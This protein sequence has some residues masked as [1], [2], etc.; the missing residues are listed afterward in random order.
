[1][2]KDRKNLNRKK[3]QP[4]PFA[5]LSPMQ[6]DLLAIA[7]IYVFTLILFRGIVFNNAAFAAGGDTATALSYQKVGEAI[8]QTE[9]VDPLWMP[10]FFSGMPT[11]G[12]VAYIP[13]NVSYLQTAVVAVLKLLFL[14]GTWSWLVVFYFL[15][16]VFMFF[17]MREWKISRIG[18]LLAAVTFLLSPFAIG[19]A[20]EGH[21]S[22]LMALVY[23][24]LFFLL[25]H[26]LFEKR[27][28][29]SFGLLS[30]CIGT[31]LL[32]NHMQMVY[33]NFMIVGLYLLYYVIR[34]ARKE[35]MVTVKRVLLFGG[36]MVI[37]LMIASYIYLS[38][39]EYS[40]Y[41]IRGSGTPGVAGGLNW[42][43]ATSWSWHPQELLTLL[44]PGFFG[45]QYPYYWGTMPFTHST[46]YIGLVPILLSIIALVYRRNTLA[47]FMGLLT[48]FMLFMSFGKHFAFFYSILFDYLPFFNKFR[49]PVMVLH[50]LPFTAAVLSAIG[51]DF[52]VEW[53][54]QAQE[55]SLGR[56]EK[57][58]T[59]AL[60]ALGGVFVLGF[61]FR[62]SLHDFFFGFMF[63]KPGEMEQ[64]RALGQEAARQLTML[65]EE[66]FALLMKDLLKFCVIG[67]IAVGSLL[68]FI[69]KKISV[70]TFSF[71]LFAILLTD[72]LIVINDGDFI[73]PQP[74]SSVTAVFQPSS[75]VSYL[76]QQPGL[77]RVYPIAGRPDMYQDNTFAYFGIQS[78]GGYSPA[79]LKIYQEM[80]DSAGLYPPRFPLAMNVINMLNARYI[81]SPGRLPD[82]G[83]LEGVNLDQAQ[84]LITYE[85]PDALPRAWFVDTALV[86][87][88][89]TML[90]ETLLDSSFQPGHT[91]LLETPLKEQIHRSDST[92]ADVTSYASSEIHISTYCS[93]QSLLVV[94]EIYY[95]AGWKAYVDESRVEIHKTN[96]ILRSVVVPEG[97]HEVVFKF[98]PPL[99]RLGWELSN[100]GWGIAGICIVA[101]MFTIPSIRRKFGK[102]SEH[103]SG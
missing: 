1:M 77:F 6:K 65:K 76:K 58:L 27:N 64:L 31:L 35:T 16:A 34:D 51:F 97:K 48:V 91:A 73:D 53:R 49:T 99:Y 93:K 4:E 19:L 83:D 96:S 71:A 30:A 69:R 102:G 66:R 100:I 50:Y 38:V 87:P 24:P 103:T 56:L 57:G 70:T 8:A 12:N 22:K 54:T 89:K 23:L 18:A 74:S 25:T 52:L 92:H 79:K 15:G 84:R 94:S 82:P 75:T 60:Y 39:Y 85:N 33:Y 2:A 42:D 72:L 21:G 62:S 80:V 86:M 14:N 37:G 43:Y 88:S 101:G 59:Y 29:L 61:L 3:Q 40:T 81:V 10:Y 90:F 26:V 17:L 11:F 98:D 46:V 20:Q 47:W 41:S 95:P 28:L 45:F 32:T 78:V 55:V 7:V 68:L 13:H 63:V 67:G 44:I 36:A 9:H 5:S